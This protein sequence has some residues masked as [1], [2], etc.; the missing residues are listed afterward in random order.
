MAKEKLYL[1]D[2]R[3]GQKFTS[4]SY[5]MT[6]QRMKEFAAEFDPQPFHLDEA[7]GAQSIFKG[8]AASGWHTAAA[9]MKL[10]VE[11]DL[12]L[13]EGLVGVGGEIS[14][15]RP[16]RAGDVLRVECEVVEITP[17]RSKPMQGM[18]KI[19]NTTLNQKDEVV[20][21]FTASVIVFRRNRG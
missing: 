1:E 10:L 4:G 12:A 9:T 19:R 8:L 5:E 20:Q 13:S 2:L 18:A 14:W 3:V 21:V 7:A 6:E 16:T 15:P 11:S 17:S